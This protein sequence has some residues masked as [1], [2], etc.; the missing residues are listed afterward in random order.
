VT[1]ISHNPTSNISRNRDKIRRQLRSLFVY[2]LLYLV[3]WIF[4]LVNQ[5]FGYTR[6][7]AQQPTWILVLSLVSLAVQ[8]AAD[9]AV[10]TAR[11]KPWRHTKGEGFWV[12]VRSGWW[13]D[14]TE[15]VGRTREEMLVDGRIARA[16]RAG[17]IVDEIGGKS[18]EGVATRQQRGN[19]N[20]MGGKDWWDVEE[21]DNSSEG[22]VQGTAGRAS[23]G[24]GVWFE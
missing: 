17:E 8:G 11:E 23:I 18:R 7:I 22:G 4:P 19:E 13:G 24:N 20:S 2:P 6:E 12:S 10:F 5:V 16:R 9:C 15:G 1:Y 14:S 21:F 3:I